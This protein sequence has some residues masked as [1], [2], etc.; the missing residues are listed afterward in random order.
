MIYVYTIDAGCTVMQLSVTN[1]SLFVE[2]PVIEV[3]VLMV[4]GNNTHLDSLI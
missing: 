1:G 2:C 4:Q 3:C